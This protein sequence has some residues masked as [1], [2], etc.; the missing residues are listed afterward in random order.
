SDRYGTAREFAA[1]LQRFLDDQPIL[2]RRPSLVDRVR[3]WSKRHPNVLV[4]GVLFLVAC[5]G[6]LSVSN[7][8]I[9]DEQDKT[10][11]ALKQ[12]KQ[13]AT[14]A[15]QRFR[16]AREAVDLLIQVSEEELVDQPALQ[17]LR[18]KL[19]EAALVYYQD[20]IQ[21]RQDDPE[22]Q[23]MLAAEQSRVQRIL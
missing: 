9:Q 20:F 5:V 3:K 13:R 4:T 15:E 16:Q 17:G 23:A 10:K 18:K 7:R 19:L 22:A 2:A 11:A 8:L 1:D 6:G 12:E 14:E 21:Q